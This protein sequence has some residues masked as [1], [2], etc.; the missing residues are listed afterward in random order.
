MIPPIAPTLLEANPQF[1]FL[2]KH[3]TTQLL[4]PD[5]STRSISLSHDPVA[6]RLRQ[7]HVQAA[8]Y[9]ILRRSLY[10]FTADESLSSEL[11]ELALNIATYLS[12][13]PT[14]NLGP[15]AHDF[16]VPEVEEF[17]DNLDTI[18][19]LLSK[20]IQEQRDSLLP[21]TVTSS[22][23]TKPV[24]STSSPSLA[25][26]LSTRLTSLHALQTQTLPTTNTALSNTLSTLLHA[27]TAHL[28]AL[29]R[30][31]ELHT[32]GTQS[33]HTHA[34][35]AYLSTV[36]AGL[37]AK[38]QTLALQAR[39]AVYTPTVQHALVSYSSH[40]RDFRERLREREEMVKR[41]LDLYEDVGGDGLKECARRYGTV[42]KEIEV[43]KGE[44]ARLE[45]ERRVPGRRSKA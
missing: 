44:I 38:V 40:L 25:S 5:A 39:H 34:R 10:S 43:V 41:E 27:H 19:P 7:H 28:A 33:R 3:V 13:A 36:A 15:E 12:E 37:E 8:K 20:H 11:V 1:A 14:M 17:Q 23:P 9:D 4:N 6:K 21:L 29:I 32:H 24:K 26:T 42:V 35:A 18:A 22:S 2:Y 16:M 31:L 45:G 30:H